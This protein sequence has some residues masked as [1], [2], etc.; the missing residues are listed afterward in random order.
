MAAAAFAAGWEDGGMPV[1]AGLAGG[2]DEP[3][4]LGT[5][6]GSNWIGPRS[7]TFGASTTTGAAAGAAVVL[8]HGTVLPKPQ[9]QNT[10][11]PAE[12]SDRPC[13][14][15]HFLQVNQIMIRSRQ[16]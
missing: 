15:P 11:V 16:K 4:V 2:G 13:V 9:S 7:G 6:T 5:P 3:G 1:I 12:A 10:M 14:L 8:S